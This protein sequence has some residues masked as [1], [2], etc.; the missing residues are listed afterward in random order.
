MRESTK[1]HP[2][3][4]TFIK[5]WIWPGPPPSSVEKIHTFF[6]KASLKRKMQY[7]DLLANFPSQILDTTLI[8]DKNPLVQSILSMVS[9]E[10]YSKNLRF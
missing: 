2:I 1:K 4:H 9:V 10:S 8:S 7:L 3:F 6:L 5:V